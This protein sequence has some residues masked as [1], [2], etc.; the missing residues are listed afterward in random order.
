[1]IASQVLGHQ[2]S[3][4]EPQKY[5]N[6]TFNQSLTSLQSIKIFP[7]QSAESVVDLSF[8]PSLRSDLMCHQVSLKSK[9]CHRIQKIFL[10]FSPS[11]A[12]RQNSKWLFSRRLQCSRMIPPPTSS[13]SLAPPSISSRFVLHLLSVLVELNP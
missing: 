5:D 12:T 9:V 8:R 6:I 4:S 1:M 11:E 3:Q 13:T 7:P 10:H 2:Y